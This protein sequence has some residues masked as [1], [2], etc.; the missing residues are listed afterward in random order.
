MAAKKDK[1][2]IEALRNDVQALQE[3][4][5]QFRDAMLTEAALHQAELQQSALVVDELPTLTDSQ[6]TD[7]ATLMAAVGHPQ[8]LRITILLT[9]NAMSVNDLVGQLGLSTTGA[10]Y[11]HLK[12]LMNEGLVEQPQRGTFALTEEATPRVYHLLTGLF[13]EPSEADADA[14]KPPK[15]KKK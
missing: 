15:K 8:R 5:W 4:F 11:H 1:F 6:L 3:S 12:V 10:A 14:G 2:G 7:A 9:Q 13:G